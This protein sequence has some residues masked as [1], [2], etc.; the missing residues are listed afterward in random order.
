MIQKII[1]SCPE[2]VFSRGPG[3][4]GDTCREL[5][6]NH[7]GCE[8]DGERDKVASIVAVE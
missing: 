8:H 5:A 2:R 7:G 1:Q 3:A 4:I 6:G